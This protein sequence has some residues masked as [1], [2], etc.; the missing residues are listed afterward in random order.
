MRFAFQSFGFQSDRLDVE[1]YPE[2]LE[3][4]GPSF[5]KNNNIKNDKNSI[6]KSNGNLIRPIVS[7]RL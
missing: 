1:Q 3:I 5:E 6:P 4:F 7:Y 2:F